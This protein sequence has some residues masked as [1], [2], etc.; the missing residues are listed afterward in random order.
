MKKMKN[1]VYLEGRLYRA[2]LEKRIAGP[3]SK[4]PGT[5]YISGDIDIAIDDGCTNIIKVYYSY[6]VP[7]YKNGNSNATYEVLNKI[8]DGQYKSVMDSSM[9]QATLLRVNTAL[10]LNDFYDKNDSLVS[11]LRNEGGFL[12]VLDTFKNVELP[13]RCKF[14]V[15]IL[16]T[17]VVRL[18]ENEEKGLPERMELHGYI[19]NFRNDIL[20]VKL[21]VK[22]PGGMDYFESLDVTS[23]NPVFTKVWGTEI[24]QVTRT[25]KVI[26]TAFGDDEITYEEKVEK[27]FLVTKAVSEPYEMDSE[28]TLQIIEVKNALSN[29]EVMLAEK[30]KNKKDYEKQNSW[31]LS[32]MRGTEDRGD[33][34]DD[35]L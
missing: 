4:N 11:V 5:E 33:D 17:K 15:D 26:E 16:L 19:F 8:L 23:K 30:L 25:E 1:D 28:D 35:L 20:P 13:Q 34:W 10:A 6:V 31:E 21:T 18:E 12:H 24:N 22:N 32:G 7:K 29:R 3:Q 9:P 2:N 27:I 14:E